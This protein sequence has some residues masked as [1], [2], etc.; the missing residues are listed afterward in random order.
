MAVTSSPSPTGLVRPKMAEICPA[1]LFGLG[2]G[3]LLE[4]LL[5]EALLDEELLDEGLPADEPMN[6]L[7]GFEVP[8]GR[9]GALIPVIMIQTRAPL[10]HRTQT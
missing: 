8:S 9:A 10:A 2:A 7:G 3:L 5:D 6:V 4:E 1:R